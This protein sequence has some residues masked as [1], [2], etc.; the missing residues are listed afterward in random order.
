M[1]QC[2]DGVSVFE[3]TLREIE[4]IATY[5]SQIVWIGY[6]FEG[7]KPGYSR[8]AK[9]KNLRCKPYPAVFG[10]PSFLHKM[11]MIWY[12]PRLVQNIRYELA[13]A[14]FVHTRGPSVP[15]LI[16][17]LISFFD[18]KRSYWH[19]YAGNWRERNPPL[20]YGIQ[21]WLLKNIKSATVTINGKWPDQ[22]S[23]MLSFENPCVELRELNEFQSSE[24][25]NFSG[26]LS[27][28]FVGA[29]IPA[30]G[31]D[32]LLRALRTFDEQ[33]GISKVYIVGD[34]TERKELQQKANELLI[35]TEFCGFLK[36]DR[37]LDV[38]RKSHV[39]VLASD[40]E[41][42]PKVIAEASAF[43]V[44]P[45]VSDVSAIGQYIKNNVSG[46]L[47]KNNT[48]QD[49]AQSLALLLSDRLAA[50]KMSEA[51]KTITTLFTYERFSE[52]IAKEVFR[53]K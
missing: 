2:S 14:E 47:L 49:I 12:I 39:I 18:L 45:I 15:A 26:N 11:R 34:G 50:Q 33:S 27:V 42:F 7:P 9:V 22:K 19:K 48:D 52:R 46:V 40:T 4:S 38:Y 3:P 29:L 53:L 30:K 10:G 25:K 51:V 16:G 13:S 28:C 8:S 36:R 5:F 43:G 1:H 6:K 17:V 21:R 20:A 41:G 23:H 44:I 31:V 37:I 35:E 24:R 32:K